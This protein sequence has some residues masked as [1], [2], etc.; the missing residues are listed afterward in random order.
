MTGQNVTDKK[1]GELEQITLD[2]QT[3]I[4][5]SKMDLNKNSG[6]SKIT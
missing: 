1:H 4:I 2:I 5:L 6:K 3:T